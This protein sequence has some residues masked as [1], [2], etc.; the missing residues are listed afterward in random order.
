MIQG[1][2]LIALLFA[3]LQLYFTRLHYR[4]GEF[5]FREWIGWS[6]IWVAFAAATIFPDMFKRFAGTVGAVRSLDLFVVLGFIVV[7]SISFYTYVNVDRLRRRLE[8]AVR[9]LAIRD[10]SPA[11]NERKPS[12]RQ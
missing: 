5:T 4:R 9:E 3:L 8:K 7:L 1:L 10:I 2:Q 6:F 11:K 12:K